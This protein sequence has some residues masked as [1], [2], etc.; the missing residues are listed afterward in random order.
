MSARHSPTPIRFGTDGWR[1]VIA[2]EFTE[3][4]AATVV[5]AAATTWAE[6]AGDL[7]RPLVVGY[8]TRFN[9]RAVAHLAGDILAANGWRVLL[10]DRPVPTPVVSY[11][12]TLHGAA[13]GLVVTASHNPARFNGIKLKGAFG[14]SATPEFTG[15]VEQALGRAPVR[16]TAAAGGRV[17]TVDL[18]PD[19][20]ARSSA[21]RRAR[22]GSSG[23]HSTGRRTAC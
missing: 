2:D 8:D 21:G 14:G 5:Q 20:V 17:E 19:Y 3:A 7:T 22:S 13:G 9:S 16:R 18:L 11:T 10:A 4:N 23:T 1:G 6:E 12:V 15:R